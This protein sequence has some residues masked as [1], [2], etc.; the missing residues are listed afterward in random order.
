MEYERYD[1]VRIVSYGKQIDQDQA[2]VS[3]RF[4]KILSR[5]NLNLAYLQV[6]KNKEAARADGMIYDQLLHYL[7]ENREE[8]LSQLHRGSYKLSPVRSIE[9]LKPNGC[10]KRKFS[11][12]TIID[13][14]I[15]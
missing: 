5:N 13:H 6:I 1:E 7:K 12:P 11:I 8:L 14:M 2:G 9:I 15:Q 3:N 10:D 4:E